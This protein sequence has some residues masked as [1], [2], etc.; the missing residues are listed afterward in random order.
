M[1]RA[2]EKELGRL[3]SALAQVLIDNLETEDGPSPSMCS[4]A[5]KFLKDN[6]ITCSISDNEDMENL[7]TA[8]KEKR[9]KRR[10]KVVGEDE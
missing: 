6:E 2:S 7:Q 8:L 1:T 5:T 3:H 9:A 4:I 10:L